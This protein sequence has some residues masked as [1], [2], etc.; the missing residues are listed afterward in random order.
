R[1]WILSPAPVISLDPYSSFLLTRLG[2]PCI[3]VADY[4]D[5]ISK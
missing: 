2:Y 5:I 4:C 1:H 3:N